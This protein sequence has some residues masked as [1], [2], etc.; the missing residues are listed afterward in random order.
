MLKN[1][2]PQDKELFGDQRE[3][4]YAIDENGRYVL[5]ESSGWD[6]A[7][8]ANNQA[9]EAISHEITD[10]LTRIRKGELSPLAYHMVANQMDEKLLAEYA[11]LFRWQVRRHLRPGPFN[12]ISP[13]LRARYGSLFSITVEELGKIPDDPAPVLIQAV[14]N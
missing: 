6:P 9:W 11:G 10:I 2:V 12:R 8:I 13:K 7:N 5:A 1:E 4:C 3:V 14:K